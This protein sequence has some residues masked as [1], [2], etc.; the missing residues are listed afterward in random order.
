MAEY[1]EDIEELAKGVHTNTM[2]F[3]DIDG[4]IYGLG[5][6][7]NAMMKWYRNEAKV[8]LAKKIDADFM[9]LSNNQEYIEVRKN[10]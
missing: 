3:M 8:M 1:L 4:Y 6:C 7:T 10:Y 2:M 5:S 9:M